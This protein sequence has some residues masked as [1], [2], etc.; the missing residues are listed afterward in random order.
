MMQTAPLVGQMLADIMRSV[1]RRIGLLDA[2]KPLWLSSRAAIIALAL[3][4]GCSFS[5]IPEHH[6]GRSRITGRVTS[7]AGPVGGT[8]IFARRFTSTGLAPIS[9]T[10]KSDA[11]GGFAL[12]LEPGS[13]LVE[14]KDAN[15][16]PAAAIVG[17][18]SDE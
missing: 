9:G 10:T 16:A 6:K 17:A 3:I 8:Q 1:K 15:N 18:V 5:R 11:T 7:N 14:A 4:D 13:Y 12:E 2:R